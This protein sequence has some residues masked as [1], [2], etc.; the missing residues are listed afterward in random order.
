MISQFW[1]NTKLYCIEHDAPSLMNIVSHTSGPMYDCP[2]CNKSISI[3]DFEKMIN[4]FQKEMEE[5]YANG[6]EPHLKN[7]VWKN[8]KKNYKVLT[9]N[10]NLFEVGVI[11]NE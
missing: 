6:E 8:K 2:I 1:K 5:A 7:S 9:H 3:Y 4:H 10:E 11:I